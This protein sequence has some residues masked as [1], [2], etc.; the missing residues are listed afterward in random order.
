M[1]TKKTGGKDPQDVREDKL[2]SKRMKAEDLVY[3]A[4]VRNAGG[5]PYVLESAWQEMV[6]IGKND[7]TFLDMVIDFCELMIWIADADRYHPEY[8]VEEYLVQAGQLHQMQLN[9]VMEVLQ[10]HKESGGVVIGP[11]E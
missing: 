6:E 3:E 4:S 1:T 9:I 8:P 7:E 10:M 11:I 5:L 2:R